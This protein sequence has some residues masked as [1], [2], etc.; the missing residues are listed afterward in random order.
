M[1]TRILQKHAILTEAAVEGSAPMPRFAEIPRRSL[2]RRLEGYFWSSLV[3]PSVE[4]AQA[5]GQ[6]LH[7][8]AGSYI[9]LLPFPR[10]SFPYT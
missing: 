10:G 6:P 8:V 2:L 9:L 1:L 5:C 3:A 4:R 7:V